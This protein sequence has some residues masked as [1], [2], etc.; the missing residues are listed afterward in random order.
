MSAD[1]DGARQGKQLGAIASLFG[2]AILLAVAPILIGVP[3]ALL[4]GIP[5]ILTLKR[6]KK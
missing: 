5:A 1:P 4:L 3:L 6:L 2:A